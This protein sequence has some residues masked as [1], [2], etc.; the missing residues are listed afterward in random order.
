MQDKS[1]RLFATDKELYDLMFSARQR[2]T[3]SVLHR[4]TRERGVFFGA[5][6]TRADLADYISMTI[7]DLDDVKELVRDAEPGTRGER[8]SSL[9]VKMKLEASEIRDIIQEYAGKKAKTKLWLC[10]TVPPMPSSQRWDTASSICLARLSSATAGQGCYL[11][12]PYRG[13]RRGNSL[14]GQ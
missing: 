14:S 10:R 5:S 6:T 13:R 3:D 8:T 11:G 7:H 2:I 9:T 4:A 12:F 1:P